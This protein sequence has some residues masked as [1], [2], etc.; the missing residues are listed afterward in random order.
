MSL[1]VRVYI[2]IHKE[3]DF[4]LGGDSEQIT[5]VYSKLPGGIIIPTMSIR[6]LTQTGGDVLFDQETIHLP[7]FMYGSTQ[8]CTRKYFSLPDKRITVS[9]Q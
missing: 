9:T 1:R 3:N 4:I 7:C 6:G 8:L 2:G 5:T